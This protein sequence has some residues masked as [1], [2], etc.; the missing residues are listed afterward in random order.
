MFTPYMRA[1]FVSSSYFGIFISAGSFYHT[2]LAISQG[3]SVWRC[4]AF[5]LLGRRLSAFNAVLSR[6]IFFS[7]FYMDSICFSG[8]GY[9]LVLPEISDYR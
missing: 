7:S 5:L 2:L 9:S 1:I 3:D 4:L 6:S 8:I